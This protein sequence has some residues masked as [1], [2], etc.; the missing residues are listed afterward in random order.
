MYMHQLQVFNGI[1]NLYY[2]Y[3]LA[4]AATHD[5]NSRRYGRHPLQ[6]HRPA[7]HLPVDTADVGAFACSVSPLIL[8]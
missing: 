4:A 6:R 1:H 8:P 5:G 3:V 7:I 2:Y